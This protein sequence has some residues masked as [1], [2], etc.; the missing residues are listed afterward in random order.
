MS[1]GDRRHLSLYFRGQKKA[2][3]EQKAKDPNRW[4]K[5]E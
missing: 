3:D 1:L 4:R 2:A 5:F